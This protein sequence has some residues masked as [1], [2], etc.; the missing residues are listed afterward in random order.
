MRSPSKS[1][2]VFVAGH[3]G[4]VGSAVVRS[5]T[6]HGYSNI[7]TR[8]RNEL[9]LQNK[10]DVQDF[11][12]KENPEHVILAAAKVGGIGANSKYV[13]EF[14]LENLEIQNNVISAAADHGVKK[15]VFLGS[16]CIYPKAATYPITEDQL[17]SGPFEPTNE[18]YALAKVAGIKLCQAYFK[19]YQ[20][21]FIS[22]M[23]TNVYG[24][25]ERYDSENSHV[26]PSMMV[27]VFEA[28]RQ[29]KESVTFWGTG[30]P[31]R[32]FIHADDLADGIVVCFEKWNQPEIVNIGSQQET[33]IF[34]LA[35]MVCKACGFKGKI[36]W[37]PSRPDGVMRKV[38]DSSRL[39]TM[40][41]KPRISLEE[42][43][44]QM[45]E[46]ARGKF[47]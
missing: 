3:L 45:A 20:K 38:M 26:I 10:R 36:L 18:P 6:R 22:V 28:I 41:W 46:E 14:L 43:L 17:L 37:D 25:N 9:N 40:N 5:L 39:R 34:E 19:E 29:K 15:L 16:S 32:E 21:N 2:K 4:F 8:T 24:P 7:L 23:P 31:L 27:K 44:R 30:K 42:G 35:Q 33:S 47:L 12:S 11:F 13:V 1:D